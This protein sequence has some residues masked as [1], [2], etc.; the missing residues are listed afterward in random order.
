MLGDIT[1]SAG[2]QNG[3]INATHTSNVTAGWTPQTLPTPYPIVIVSSIVSFVIAVIGLRTAL[4]TVQRNKD[5][6]RIQY[7]EGYSTWSFRDRWAW[8]RKNARKI[9]NNATQPPDKQSTG[10]VEEQI[11]LREFQ[12]QDPNQPKHDNQ[13]SYHSPPHFDA[14]ERPIPNPST[15]YNTTNT[16]TNNWQA[17]L[18]DKLL[19]SI[20]LTYTTLRSIFALITTLKVSITRQGTH[21]AS[22]SL[23]LLYLSLQTFMANRAIPRVITLALVTD[24]LIVAI[25]FLITT[26]D[27]H[28]AAYGDISVLSGN[29]P[30]FATDCTT[31]A[32]N[33]TRVGCGAVVGPRTS[34]SST[35]A[36]QSPNPN[37]GASFFP[38]YASAGDINMQGSALRKIEGVV[39]A[40]G[41]FWVVVTL[42]LTIYEAF[43]A[44]RSISSFSNLLTPIPQADEW[45]ENKNTGKLRRRVGWKVT[46]FVAFVGVSGAFVVLVLSIAGHAAG[47][48]R[49]YTATYI[50]SFGPSVMTNV[51]YSARSAGGYVNSTEYWGNSTSWSDCYTVT[52]PS[53]GDGFLGDWLGRSEQV[54]LRLIALL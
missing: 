33:W 47:E 1:G 12:E 41:T 54:P 49:T 3:F 28:S 6:V 52:T 13:I 17:P 24:L 51:T 44:F 46:S 15:P 23:L 45:V 35:S 29:C 20:S 30:V 7:P 53:S 36:K 26:W 9:Q 48:T 38:P 42:I 11:P 39:G 16:H 32:R 31:Q 10:T 2:L 40:I 18:K 4:R 22:S 25:A 5:P 34:Y 14:Q 43:R 27:F 50:D 19:V 8:A 21:A 37:H